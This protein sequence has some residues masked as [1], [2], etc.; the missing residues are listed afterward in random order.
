MDGMNWLQQ[1]GEL[2]ARFR[3]WFMVAPW[4]QAVRVRAGSRVTTFA[5]GLHFKVPFLDQVFIQNT[6]LRTLN[7]PVQTVT[8][9]DGRTLTMSGTVDFAIVDIRKLYGSIHHVETIL[10]NRALAALAREIREAVS[11]EIDWPTV[12]WTAAHALQEDCKSWGLKIGEVRMTDIALVRSYRLIQDQ[13]W[14]TGEY[15]DLGKKEA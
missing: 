8:T 10:Y 3:L 2:V 6:R 1:L 9:K 14:G 7:L 13:R 11:T 4:E 15:L 12:E 5:A